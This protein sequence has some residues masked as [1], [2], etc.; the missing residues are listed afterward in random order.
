MK[1]D[2]LAVGLRKLAQT[3]V[4]EMNAQGTEAPLE[5]R[6]EAIKIVSALFFG[7]EKISARVSDDEPVGRNMRDWQREIRGENAQH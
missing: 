4:D 2:K 7:L 3:T 6:L 1:E 5:D